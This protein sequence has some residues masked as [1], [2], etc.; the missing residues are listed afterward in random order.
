MV[1]EQEHGRSLYAAV[2]GNPVEFIFVARLSARELRACPV[3][4]FRCR[5][6]AFY[7]VFLPDEQF[8]QRIRDGLVFRAHLAVVLARFN[9]SPVARHFLSAKVLLH[10]FKF[11]PQR[12]FSQGERNGIGLNRAG[13]RSL[14]LPSALPLSGIVSSRPLPG[15]KTC[16]P[17]PHR[18]P[19]NSLCQI[20]SLQ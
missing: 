18:S 1:A 15:G 10:T 17:I 9:L 16:I 19:N 14:F 5:V 7:V 11:K 4:D 13:K 12:Q 8:Q 20:F 3:A 6:L 2:R